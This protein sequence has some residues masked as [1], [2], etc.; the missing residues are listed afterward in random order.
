MKKILAILLAGAMLLCFA[1]CGLIGEE[2]E[3]E[4]TASAAV[5]EKQVIYLVADF[6]CGASEPVRKEYPVEYED[7]EGDGCGVE[8][9]A[10]GLTQLTGLPFTLDAVTSTNNRTMLISWAADSVLFAG[11]PAEPNEAFLFFDYDSMVW[12]VLDSLHQ[13]ILRNIPAAAEMDVYYTMNGGEE[14][15]L[16]NLS[17]PRNF[18]LETPYMGSAFYC[19]A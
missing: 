7:P 5:D 6:S 2:K 18:G 11:P 16:E 19:A 9:M 13:T 14:L 17:P 12:F 10:M 4:T 8:E 3:E 1:A 15:V